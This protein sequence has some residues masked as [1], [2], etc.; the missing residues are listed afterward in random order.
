[1]GLSGVRY[2]GE[3]LANQLDRLICIAP[4]Q[5]HHAEQ[6]QRICVVG[7]P[8]QKLSVKRLG[9]LEP[10]GPMMFE[11]DG[12]VYGRC[13]LAPPLGAIRA[14]CHFPSIPLFLT[15]WPTIRADVYLI[16]LPNNFRVFIQKAPNKPLNAVAG[17]LLVFDRFRYQL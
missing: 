2:D 5:G 15:A 4:C 13:R 12:Q 11:G 3:C 17:W 8:L 7:R 9:T 6:M 10:S 16:K 14:A 1:M